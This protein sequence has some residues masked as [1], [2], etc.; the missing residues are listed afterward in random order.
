MLASLPSQLLL[1]D[2][3]FPVVAT[4]KNFTFKSVKLFSI[5]G[6]SKQKKIPIKKVWSKSGSLTTTLGGRPLCGG[7]HPKVPLFLTPP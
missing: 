4:L 1:S 5:S 3:A 2:F 6:D 7:H